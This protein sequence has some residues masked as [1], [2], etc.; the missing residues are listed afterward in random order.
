M[1]ASVGKVENSGAPS[2]NG[3]LPSIRKGHS[4]TGMTCFQHAV[5]FS[6]GRLSSTLSNSKQD[7]RQ[8]SYKKSTKRPGWKW[9]SRYKI[10]KSVLTHHIS[11][12]H[13]NLSR[14]N[15]CPLR[16]STILCR[17]TISLPQW[18][19]STLKQRLH[20]P[21]HFHKYHQLHTHLENRLR[22]LYSHRQPCACKTCSF[23]RG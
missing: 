20:P 19:D 1:D 5:F 23:P 2:S 18:I 13:G 6:T 14:Q 4:H 9:I 15:L 7:I 3:M 12:C 22:S 21:T 16:I 10:S 11:P 8:D 17:V